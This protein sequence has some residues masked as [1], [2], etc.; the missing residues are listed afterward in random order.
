[1][2]M[3][4]CMNNDNRNDIC[5]CTNEHCYREGLKN[6][7]LILKLEIPEKISSS[8]ISFECVSESEKTQREM[9]VVK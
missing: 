6:H 2:G 5:A 8:E 3:N 4:K 9:I 1:M 7:Q